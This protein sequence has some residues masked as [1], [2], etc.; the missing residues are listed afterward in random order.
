MTAR[1]VLAAAA[2]AT[3]ASIAAADDHSLNNLDNVRQTAPDISDVLLRQRYNDPNADIVPITT[4]MD[5]GIDGFST[6][7]LSLSHAAG[8]D[9]HS[10]YAVFG[11]TSTT[12]CCR[13]HF[14]FLRR[15]V[16]ISA[17]SARCSRPIA[18]IQRST[19]T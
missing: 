9:S 14:T 4:A 8:S 6:F 2:A 1:L 5:C 16:L 13:R 19:P 12:H 15:L 17:A 7:Q 18:R 10:V 11:F 3:A